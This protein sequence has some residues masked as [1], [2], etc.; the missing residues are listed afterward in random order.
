MLGKG[1]DSVQTSEENQGKQF[2]N[3]LPGFDKT[4]DLRF[5]STKKPQD[6][7]MGTCFM[8]SLDNEAFLKTLFKIKDDKLSFSKVIEIVTQIEDAAK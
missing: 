1:T 2:Q 6:E 3:Y 7:T 4:R 5:V 8:N